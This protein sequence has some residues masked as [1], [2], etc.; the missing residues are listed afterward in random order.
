MLDSSENESRTLKLLDKSAEIGFVVGMIL[1]V[2]IGIHSALISLNG[3]G[4]TMSQE[5]LTDTNCQNVVNKYSWNGISKLRPHLPQP[6][7]TNPDTTSPSKP[8]ATSSD[9]GSNQQFQIQKVARDTDI[10][11]QIAVEIRKR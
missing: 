4:A 3:K 10:S 6:V 7:Q 5:K 2:I 8:S 1:I 11:L 9:N